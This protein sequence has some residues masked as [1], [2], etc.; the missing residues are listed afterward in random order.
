MAKDMVHGSRER[1]R[2]RERVRR[3]TSHHL[4]ADTLTRWL[5]VGPALV[6]D[7]HTRVPY[8]PD[9][10]LVLAYVRSHCAIC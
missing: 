9:C 10:L 4:A 2:E 5:T 6:H 3:R 7:H 8:M 1:E